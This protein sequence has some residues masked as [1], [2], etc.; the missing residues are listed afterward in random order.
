MESRNRSKSTGSSPRRVPVG[1]GLRKPN[2]RAALNA[3]FTLRATKTD[4]FATFGRASV[5]RRFASKVTPEPTSGCHLW[6]AARNT[7]GYPVVWLGNANGRRVI[8]YAHRVALELDGQALQPGLTVD[9]LCNN[10]SCVNPRHLQLVTN[11]VNC[12]RRDERRPRSTTA[13]APTARQLEVL[14]AIARLTVER[15]F[16][17]TIRELGDELG[18][19][20]TNG[21]VDFLR[22]LERHGW[23]THVRGTARS[24]VL[25]PSGSAWL[26]T[27]RAA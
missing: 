16:P 1:D 7:A 21:V 23:L 20:S 8:G 22:A 2:A 3:R 6:T 24:T 9:H 27:A 26:A 25:T 5:E 12:Q 13:R 18:I 4:I 11:L 17:P 10:K 15:H 14:R 19:S